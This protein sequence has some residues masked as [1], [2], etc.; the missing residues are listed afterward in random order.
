MKEQYQAIHIGEINPTSDKYP[1][2]SGKATFRNADVEIDVLLQ[3]HCSPSVAKYCK[4][5]RVPEL[6]YYATGIF[7]F[8]LAYGFLQEVL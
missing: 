7:I 8:Y 5:N 1:E 2:K 6:I 3:R 4:E